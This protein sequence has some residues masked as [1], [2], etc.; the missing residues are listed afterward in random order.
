[1]FLRIQSVLDSSDRFDRNR[2]QEP[3]SEACLTGVGQCLPVCRTVIN[4][5]GQVA[6]KGLD[7]C[8]VGVETVLDR[9]DRK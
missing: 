9:F 3:R 6:E 1:M 4:G 2:P 5:V 8:G 7:G